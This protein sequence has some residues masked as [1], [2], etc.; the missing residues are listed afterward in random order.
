MEKYKKEKKKKNI[1]DILEKIGFS[2]NEIKIYLKLI[3]LG[4]AKAGKISKECGL[5]R[6]SAYNA[7]TNLLNKGFISYA[8]IANV[9]WFQ[10]INPKRILEYINEQREDVKNILP[11]LEGKYKQTKLKGQVTLHK[12]IKGVESVFRDILRNARNSENLIFGSEGQLSQK[13]PYFYE[14]FVRELKENNIK[15]RKI[16][17][18]KRT[19]EYKKDNVRFVDT[20][21]E[22]PVVTN[23]YEDKIA[24]IIWTDEPESI[25][26]DN[27]EAA[28]S[29]RSYFE[30]MWK[31]AIKK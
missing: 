24:I 13:M 18:L 21:K 29:Y 20:D 15:S 11:E 5:D 4:S 31:N 25:I 9:K 16:I 12:G 7:I 17:R 27:K 22:S 10:A 6:S 3:E 26:I 23:I 19:E 1:D 30:F 2:K 8:N 14:H 28:D